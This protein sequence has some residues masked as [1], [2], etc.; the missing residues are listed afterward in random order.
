MRSTQQLE[1][2]YQ[3]LSNQNN[4][5][6]SQQSF[7]Q[8]NQTSS[9]KQKIFSSKQI[10]QNINY[11]VP[12]MQSTQ[13]VQKQNDKRL[14]SNQEISQGKPF[15]LA[16]SHSTNQLRKSLNDKNYFTQ[17]MSKGTPGYI[18]KNSSKVKD[19]QSLNA[20][21]EY[22]N[23]SEIEPLLQSQDQKRE[24]F[25]EKQQQLKQKSPISNG[26]ILQSDFKL[27]KNRLFDFQQQD[28][29]DVYVEDVD[30]SPNDQIY[31]QSTQL[32]PQQLYFSSSKKNQ[33][34][35]WTG[36]NQKRIKTANNT[37]I[38]KQQSSSKEVI[39]PP[40]D[41]IMFKQSQ[42][43]GTATR[44]WNN[45][46][47][48][49]NLANN[50]EKQLNPTVPKFFN[51]PQYDEIVNQ[52]LADEKKMIYYLKKEI[53][54]YRND[55][56]KISYTSK[57]D[58]MIKL[59]IDE[60]DKQHK[61]INFLENKIK[62][63]KA[64]I[65]R[66]EDAMKQKS[67]RLLLRC[68]SAYKP[69]KVQKDLINV[70][71]QSRSRSQSARNSRRGES[72]G[73]PEEQKKN[74]D[75]QE[76]T[77]ENETSVTNHQIVQGSIVE[78]PDELMQ[79]LEQEYQSQQQRF[80]NMLE[81]HLTQVEKVDQ[82]TQLEED[83][84]YEDPK[85]KRSIIMHQDNQKLTRVVINREDLLFDVC[86]RHIS[87]KQVELNVNALIFD[88]EKTISLLKQYHKLSDFIHSHKLQDESKLTFFQIL[89]E[90]QNRAANIINCDQVIYCMMDQPSKELIQF[91]KK[92]VLK[93]KWAELFSFK[94]ENMGDH[95]ALNNPEEIK[96]LIN[97]EKLKEFLGYTKTHPIESIIM[98]KFQI[99]LKQ[100][101]SIAINSS[102]FDFSLRG[103]KSN[104]QQQCGFFTQ[105]DNE[106]LQQLSVSCLRKLNRERDLDLKIKL[107]RTYRNLFRIGINLNSRSNYAS[108][109]YE[110]EKK[111]KEMMLVKNVTILIIDHDRQ[112]FVKLNHHCIG[113]DGREF[114]LSESEIQQLDLPQDIQIE[115]NLLYMPFKGLAQHCVKEKKT[116]VIT[117][118]LS[119]QEYDKYIDIDFD[120]QKITPIIC[121]PCF[122]R[123]DNSRVE[124][125]IEIEF[126][127]K[128]YLS[129]NPLMG[130]QYGEF[131]LD[132]V[133]KEQ[134]E[135]FQNQLR[136]S[137]E[138]LN[139]L[140]KY[141]QRLKLKQNGGIHQLTDMLQIGDALS[142]IKLREQ[143]TTLD[144]QQI[145]NDFEMLRPLSEIGIFNDDKYDCLSDGE[146]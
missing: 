32:S 50:E 64:R 56:K 26:Q 58:V 146:Q 123:E 51:G 67:H 128:H 141:Q 111:L 125:L 2:I 36:T 81:A 106:I 139:I 76:V 17:Q 145:N 140:K 144:K 82:S 142:P 98:T 10:D 79:Q 134:L 109:I 136:I 8:S 117:E 63:Q 19:R 52:P 121:V 69:I 68:G 40:K 110:S 46:K 3:P 114:E 55:N 49:P 12:L 107:I 23:H 126:K 72:Q 30:G 6:N 105:M 86:G 70:E 5:K 44:F 62:D 22:F 129:S 29:F 87:R 133:A 45:M 115:G 42:M 131:K 14:H 47:F 34:T 108:L 78:N 59:L 27:S 66:M 132:I 143:F 77:A 100:G 80:M 28:K 20:G 57:K 135:I 16:T 116:L 127:M 4:I 21:E 88:L 48:N 113:P 112:S 96:N 94:Y 130:G 38:I 39:I 103:M 137:I 54:E 120:S 31:Q 71:S 75:I 124:A 1:Q 84:L 99:L 74:Q 118:P 37:Q 119:Y 104:F 11:Q 24:S 15:V 93:S 101:V 43:S 33:Q 85:Y 95:F 35:P 89:E 41:Q 91:T 25:I 92:Q 18:V 122:N 102:T 7:S 138:R 53:E 83:E 61:R 65:L 60:L 97:V 9:V 73:D 90:F 13:R